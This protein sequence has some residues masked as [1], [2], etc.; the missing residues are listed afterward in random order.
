MTLTGLAPWAKAAIY[1]AGVEA[2][3]FSPG[4]KWTDNVGGDSVDQQ[5]IAQTCPVELREYA[6]D[7]ARALV[8]NNKQTI[9]TLANMLMQKRTLTDAEVRQ[10]MFGR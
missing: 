4:W 9:A 5:L 3:R 6:R 7:Q 8:A 2:E 10:V 1:A